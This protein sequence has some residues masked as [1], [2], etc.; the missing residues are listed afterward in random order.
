MRI[1]Y[2]ETT[3]Y[4]PSSAHFQEALEASAARGEHQFRFLDE[5]AYI[6]SAPST[7]GRIANRL[8]RRPLSGYQQLNR[9]LVETA[10]AIDPDL[11]L[12]GKGRWFTPAALEAAKKVSGATLVNWATDDPFNR[13]V[14]SREIVKSIPV[15]D[16]YV[17]TKKEIMDDV[18]R[19]GCANL[20]YVRFGYKPGVHFP[21]SPA[22]DG[23]RSRFACDVM[24]AGGCDAHRAKYFEE[25]IRAMPDVRLHLYGGYWERV[26]ALRPYARGFAVGRDYRLAVGS[27]KISANLVRRSN[28]DD[29]VMRTFEIPACGGFMLTERSTT[30]EELF[31]EDKEA[32]FF[33]SPDEFVAKIRDYLAR[34]EDRRRIAAES[35]RKIMHGGHTYG[36]RLA[37]ISSAAQSVK[38]SARSATIAVTS[39]SEIESNG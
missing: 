6:T 25:L 16:L 1:L 30:H 28:R 3:A 27:A 14:N 33:S 7:A 24:F 31:S 18:R 5:A 4:S 26:H 34:D 39:S 37:E 2:V 17:C 36:D 21:E 38:A 13:A 10:A 11:I 15:Y 29:H 19:A 12:I 32:A 23:E 8:A 22:T 35:H 9:A 20:A